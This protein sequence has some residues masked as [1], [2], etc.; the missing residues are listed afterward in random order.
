M[1]KRGKKKRPR[2]SPDHA[3]GGQPRG[4]GLATRS[5]G[6]VEGSLAPATAQGA[7]RTFSTKGGGLVIRK[8]GVSEIEGYGRHH[9][10]LVLRLVI[11]RFR[12]SYTYR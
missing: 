3:H 2:V 8:L 4:A 5:L 10:L 11:F 1:R 12:F 6:A 9:R 7:S